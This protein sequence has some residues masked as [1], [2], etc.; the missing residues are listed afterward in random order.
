MKITRSTMKVEQVFKIDH[1]ALDK[2]NNWKYQITV[3]KIIEKST[4]RL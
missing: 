2:I 1:F 4:A 3:L